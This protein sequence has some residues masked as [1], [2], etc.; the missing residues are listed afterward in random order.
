MS[1]IHLKLRQTGL[2]VDYRRVERLYREADLQVRRRK[3]RRYQQAS[4]GSI[5]GGPAASAVWSMGNRVRQYRGR[6]GNQVLDDRRRCRPRGSEDQGGA[7]KFRQDVSRVL[8]RLAIQRGLPRRIRTDNGKEVRGKPMVAWAQV[9]GV[10]LRL[11][12]P[13]TPI[14][15]ACVEYFDVLS[16]DK[17]LNDKWLS[18]S[19][20]AR[21]S[22]ES[23]RRDYN[24]ERPKT[25]M[26]GLTAVQCAA[27]LAT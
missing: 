17:C 8:N 22:I 18:R 16:R 21:A 23:L 6:A 5:R 13:G 15:N 25:A 7:E 10:T 2:V 12:E 26:G 19:L 4:V 27:R 14:Q 1:I 3:V 20:Y 9:E 11:V 24:E